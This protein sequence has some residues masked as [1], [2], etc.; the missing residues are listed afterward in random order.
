MNDL[1]LKGVFERYRARPFVFVRPGGNAGDHLIWYG[2][3]A[4]ARRLGL[5]FETLTHKEFM[6]AGDFSPETVIYLHGSGGYNPWWSGTPMVELEKSVQLHPGVVIQ[7]PMTCHPDEAFLRE[8]VVDRIAQPRAEKVY[9]FCRERY[10]HEAMQRVLP[11][12]VE[13]GLDH[14]T[15]LH[16]RPEDLTQYDVAGY[17]LYVIR[18]DKEASSDAVQDLVAPWMDPAIDTPKFEDWLRVHARAGRIVSNR[19]HSAIVSTILGK[20][21]TLFPNSYKKNRGVWEFSLEQRGV[22]WREDGPPVSLPGR[23]VNSLTPLRRAFSSK[24]GKRL[25]RRLKGIA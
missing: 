11:E 12:W 1:D 22:A 21:T 3:D 20:P 5:S 23:V 9:M 10:S 6:A 18:R 19:L 2:A 24:R 14:D 25:V 17:T 15:A 4:L 16:L 8:R 13:L 7:G